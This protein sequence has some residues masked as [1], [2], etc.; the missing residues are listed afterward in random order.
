MHEHDIRDFELDQESHD[1]FHMPQRMAQTMEGR[2]RLQ[3]WGDQ[4]VRSSEYRRPMATLCP[5]EQCDHYERIDHGSHDHL[6]HDL[7][8]CRDGRFLLTDERYEPESADASSSF[9]RQLE[10]QS[11]CT[12]YAG[13]G[14]SAS[15]GCGDHQ[16]P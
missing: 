12:G 9:R 5:N 8:L 4:M 16:R 2:D 15:N 14:A 3:W 7:W 6:V 11:C 13:D 10:A 1:A